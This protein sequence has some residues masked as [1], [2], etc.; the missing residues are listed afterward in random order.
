MSLPFS[1]FAVFVVV[2][3][4]LQDDQAAAQGRRRKAVIHDTSGVDHRGVTNLSA[5]IWFTGQG[6]IAPFFVT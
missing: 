2:D 6:H 3:V 4:Q 5:P 1:H